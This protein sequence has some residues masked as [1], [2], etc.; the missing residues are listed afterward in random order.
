MGLFE[1]KT[2]TERNKTIAAI[3]LSVL[4]VLI[5]VYS[6]GGML[7]PRGSSTVSSDIEAE[8]P[9]PPPASGDATQTVPEPSANLALID[10]DY[11]VTAVVYDGRR[12]NAP[13]SGRNIFAFYEPPAGGAPTPVTVPTFTPPPP[14][15]EAPMLVRFLTPNST[16]AGSKDFRLEA[17][18]EKFTES[19]RI[20]FNGSALQTTFIGPDRLAATVPAS[21]I[22]RSGAGSV[23]VNTPDGSRYSY[24][25]SFNI[26]EPPRPDFDYI[27]LIA[28][29]HYNNDTAYFQDRGRRNDDPFTAR[30]NDIV[31]GRFRVISISS[32]EV[33]FEDIRLGFRHKLELLRPPE[34]A[35]STAGAGFPDPVD[36]VETDIPGIPGN[37]RRVSPNVR[38]AN[39]TTQDL[40]Q[41]IEEFQK[42]M[43]QNQQKKE[44]QGQEDPQVPDPTDD[45]PPEPP[46]L[47]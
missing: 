18:G 15:P 14:T 1:G 41:A 33:E 32:K 28:R 38:P 5:L 3:V 13:I 7:I 11:M 46:N 25:V 10:R 9:T 36:N 44:D 19:T 22:S 8:S 24:P 21:L 43:Q 29:Q 47:D 12:V 40:N 2:P 39:P 16:Y 34:G 26:I 20:V 37:I 6:F 42:Q 35:G 30:L 31:K 27:G 4:A 45:P 23:F 17:I